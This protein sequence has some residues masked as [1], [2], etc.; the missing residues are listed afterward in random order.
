MGALAPALLE[1]PPAAQATG[2]ARSTDWRFL[3]PAPLRMPMR[4]LIVFGI[5]PEL[6]AT[7]ATIRAQGIASEVVGNPSDAVTGDAVVALA[8]TAADPEELAAHVDENGALYWEIDRRTPGGFG[9]TPARAFDRLAAQGLTPTAAYWVKPGFPERQMYL[10]V[11]SA[12]AFRWYLNTLYGSPTRHG[13]MLKRV[14]GAVAGNGRLGTLAPCY[15]VTA[16]RGAARPPA[17]LEVA[18]A[19]RRWLQGAAHPVLLAHAGAEWSRVALLLFGTDDPVPSK[20]LKLP[21]TSAFNRHVVWEHR[22]LQRLHATLSPA[23]RASIPTSRLLHW[24]DL[25]VDS[26]SYVTGA[27]L[28]SRVG[29]PTIEALHDLHVA[30]GWLAAF[31]CRTVVDR[32]AAEEWL[33]QHLVNGLCREYA[34]L[35]GLDAPEARLFDLVKR[36]LEMCRTASLPLVWQHADFGPWNVYRDGSEL[37]VIDWEVARIGPVLTDLVYFAAH[38]GAAVARPTAHADW[39]ERMVAL[40]CGRPAR[41]PLSRAI[42]E[43][44]T[45]YMHRV[46]LHPS[47]SPFLLV[48]TFVEQAIDRA[49]RLAEVGGDAADRSANPFVA[50][51]HTVAQ[52]TDALFPRGVRCAL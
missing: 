52:H 48:Y 22:V 5:S 20:I 10:P 33:T 14:L 18:G 39:T 43:E 17:L 24:N 38:W 26:E 36:S 49:R 8:G 37:R 50:W 46:G 30:S 13:R 31:H 41:D 3:L 29:L 23:Q 6:E 32:T 12:G 27:A 42:R 2:P 44:T 4:R 40:F 16:V 28:S 19:A 34:D 7:L 47:L 11:A 9:L 15:A 45:S 1:G 21:R 35:F 25:T 51:V